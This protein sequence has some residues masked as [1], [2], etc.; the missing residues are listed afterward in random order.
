MKRD[1]FICEETHKRDLRKYEKR[2][3]HEGYI[4]VD[5][6][7]PVCCDNAKE[8]QLYEKRPIYTKRDLRKYEKR[9][10]HEGYPPDPIN[11]L[12]SLTGK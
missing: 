9:P 3:T 2:P 8:T 1:P 11:P 5:F 6:T 4:H 7:I 12:C 10:T